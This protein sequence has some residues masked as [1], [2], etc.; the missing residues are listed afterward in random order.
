ML[1]YL[2]KVICRKTF[3]KKLFFVGVLKVNDEN[4][5]I[6][7]RIRIHTKMSWIRN[8]AQQN[9]ILVWTG[10]VWTSGLR[11]NLTEDAL[12]QF[13]Q[14]V[15]TSNAFDPLC[16]EVRVRTDAPVIFTMECNLPS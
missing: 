2:Q 9:F 11:W 8:T 4:R 5:R 7:I 15:S 1:K 14:L 16:E 3:L 6:R 13:G 10:R 12:L